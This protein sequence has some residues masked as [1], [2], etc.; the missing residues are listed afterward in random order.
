M[1]PRNNQE[2]VTMVS[3]SESKLPEIT[4]ESEEGFVDLV[5]HVKEYNQLAD[6]S[7]TI[8]A[9]GIHRGREVGFELVLGPTWKKGQFGKGIPLEMGQGMVSYRRVG[10]K[11]DVFLQILDE[12][13]RT[14]QNPRTMAA[15]T[16]FTG[17]SLAGEPGNLTS[18]PVKI[19]LFYEQGCEDRY[20]ELYTNIDLATG[21][22]EVREKD[23]G[24]RSQVIQ[25][26]R[27]Q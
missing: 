11:S 19:K 3:N 17:V 1:Q 27:G 22:L 4:S 6:G 21:K 18:G 26:L 10:P 15:D 8:R 24:Y 23:E 5:F 16:S 20:A 7:Q 12:L 13:Y 14:Q 9:A 25:A 2:P